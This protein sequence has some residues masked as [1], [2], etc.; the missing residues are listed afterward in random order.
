MKLRKPP[1]SNQW[2]LE[3]KRSVP[4]G[5]NSCR[6]CSIFLISIM[7]EEEKNECL[8]TWTLHLDSDLL[9]LILVNDS[10]SVLS[11]GWLDRSTNC[12][13]EQG[14]QECIWQRA[15]AILLRRNMKCVWREIY[16]MQKG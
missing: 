3:A 14:W 2:E 9:L 1:F 10:Y 6:T 8:V 15:N 4:W 11:I 12:V 13:S 16:E 5:F 7:G